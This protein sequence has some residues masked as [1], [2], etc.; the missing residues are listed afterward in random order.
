MVSRSL[1]R[2]DPAQVGSDASRGTHAVTGPV[3]I[4][5]GGGHAKV[6]IDTARAAG[7]TPAGVL[8]VNPALAGKSVLGV[9]I[10]IA[11]EGADLAARIGPASAFLAIG[12]NARRRRI[13]AANPGLSWAT[14]V[15]PSAVLGEGVSLGAGVLIA[16]GA[17]IQPDARIGAQGIVN[18]ASSIDHDCLIGDFVHIAP[19]ARLAGGVRVG[20]GALVGMGALVP[21][22]RAIGAWACVAAG[23]V[24]AR[25]VAEHTT[26]AGVPA[27]PLARSRG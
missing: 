26:V 1:N 13:A 3:W 11:E 15:H 25:D 5:G 4:I 20:E 18:T 17:V 9:A 21:P 10:S 12:D 27:R 8:D 19:G 6:V 23:A 24:V 22:V 7:W 2:V 14:L 16:A